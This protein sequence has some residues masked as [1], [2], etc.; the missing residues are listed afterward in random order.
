MYRIVLKTEGNKLNVTESTNVLKV[1]TLNHNVKIG[2]TQNVLKIAETKNVLNVKT[3]ERKI[4]IQEV[5][6]QGKAGDVGFGLIA[7]GLR[8]QVLAKESDEG[9]DYG[10]VTPEFVDKT[11][12]QD[13]HV[14]NTVIVPHNL[15]KFP[16]VSI[17]DSAGDEVEGSVSYIDR[18]NL[19]IN[20]SVSFSGTVT[21]N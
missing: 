8:G 6:R 10:W 20:F 14:T 18:M 1:T 4:V 12:T 9:F 16:S 17:I 13:F 15:D 21:C 2:D 5:G 3:Q 7:G 19:A 11:Y